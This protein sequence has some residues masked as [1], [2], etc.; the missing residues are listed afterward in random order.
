M[1]RFWTAV[2]VASAAALAV[3][4][5]ND[6]GNTFQG[7]TGAALSSLSPSTINACLP[8][9]GGSCPDLTLMVNGSGFVAKTVVL[10]NGGKLKTTVTTGANGNV[11]MITADVPAALLT[12]P[13][14]AS[15]QTLNP[16]SGAGNNGLS[17]PITFVI[18]VVPNPVPAITNINPM[19]ATPGSGPLT[20]TIT[21]PTSGPNAFLP[22]S[23]PSGGSQVRWNTTTQTTLPLLSVTSSSIQATVSAA[24]LANAGTATIT[25]YNP[26]ATDPNCQLNCSGSGGGSSNAVPFTIGTAGAAKASLAT[27]QVQ[28]ETPA[29]S[30]DGRYVAYTASQDGHSQ[31]F[32]RDTCQSA[33][34]SCQP[35]TILFSA[36]P[37]GAAG[38]DDSHSPSLSSNGR[39]LAFSSAATNLVENA[40]KGRQV[41]LRDT[42]LGAAVACTPSIQLVSTDPNGSLVGT[43]NILPSVSASG[44]FVAFLAI[45]PSHQVNHAWAS[46]KSSSSV[47]NSGFRQVFVRDTCQGA[48]N[49]MPKTTRISFQPGDGSDATPAGPA[50]SGSANHVA[51]AGENLATLFTRSVAVDDGVFLAITK[52]RQ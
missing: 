5:C 15:V 51:L 10:W 24:L 21:G 12:K 22:T 4:G 28:E 20:L 52:D 18:N 30:Q 36:A 50:M 14:S 3:A 46:A 25:V 42:C 38:N 26:P 11:T 31:I 29:L 17:N 23:D 13:G 45:T 41:Y 19:S 47:P 6:Y 1:N 43:E 27:A 37:D 40:P 35:R 44:R 2:A 49:C 32:V 48:P 39:Y 33:E 34:A 9:P 7:Y 8:P 16:F